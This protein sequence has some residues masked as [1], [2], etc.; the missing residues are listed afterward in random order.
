[1][2]I[3]NAQG[4]DSL[5][6]SVFYNNAGGITSSY[7]YTTHVLTLS[8]SA[9]P[10]QYQA[11]LQSV[12]LYTTSTVEGTRTINVVVYD[13]NDTGD[14]ASNTGVVARHRGDESDAGL[15]RRHGRPHP[16]GDLTLS[17]STLYGTTQSGGAYGNGAIFSIPVVGGTPTV[18]ASFNGTDGSYSPD[19]YACGDLT[20]SGSMLYG[21]T[22]YGGAYGDGVVFSCPVTGGT[23]TVL[24]TFDATNGDLPFGDLTLSGSTLYGTTYFGGANNEGTIFSVP[25]TGGTPTTLLSFNGTNGENPH[26]GLTLSGSTL[27]GMASAGGAN[28]D[29]VVFSIPVTGG[30]PTI[31][32][33]FNG[34]DGATPLGSLTLSGS[35]LYGMTSV[36][37]A[38]FGT[39]F[40]IP[41]TGGAPTLLASFNGTDGYD[42]GGGLTLSGS[43][44]YGMTS[45][46]VFSIPVTGGTP[47]TLYAVGQGGDAKSAGLTLSGS[48]LYGTTYFGGQDN[49]GTI[50]AIDNFSVAPSGTTNTFTV[51][52]ARWR[53]TRASPWP[54][55]TPI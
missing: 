37:G 15:V 9:T 50:F 8:G 43:T 18:L 46:D 33:S 55:T 42:P 28:S 36:G 12:W 47:T 14:V 24:A 16:A 19:A 54:A 20:L 32:V 13:S 48:T 1:M 34:T 10:A 31:L 2:T 29:G 4:P 25:V 5:S 11:A 39:I 52:G 38:G 30:S 27:Y 44:L 7:N 35:T 22:Q 45:E 21:V 23:P 41:V 40:S 3:T 6:L 53:S 17:G 26:G 49:D 51:G